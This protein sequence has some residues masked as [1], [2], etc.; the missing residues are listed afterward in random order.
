MRR[1]LTRGC[2]DVR[3]P[4]R[5]ALAGRLALPKHAFGRDVIAAMGQWRY[6]DHR[7][8]PDIPQALHERH[9]ALAPRTVPHRLARYDALVA[10]SVQ[11]TPRLQRLPQ[12]RGRALFAL[13]GLHP[14]VGHAVLW[15]LRACLAGEVLLARSFLSATH[16]ELAHLVPEVQQALQGPMVGGRSDGPPSSRTAGAQALPDVPPQWCH[17]PSLREAAQ[18]I[19]EAARPAT[20]MR[21]KRVRGMRPIERKLQGRTDPEAE[22]MRGYG[23]AVRR[24]LTAAGRPPVAASG[25]PL[26]PRLSTIAESLERGE[27]RGPGPRNADACTRSSSAGELT[28]RPCGPP[29]G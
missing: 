26:Q 5:P 29:C 25:L 3:H 8:I 28:R 18:P 15:V 16:E 22:G 6:A 19:Y 1:C 2:P 27:K 14:D 24:A 20:K 17:C 21:P 10:L 9:V 7:S 12:A 11:D 4:Y 13:A 23:S